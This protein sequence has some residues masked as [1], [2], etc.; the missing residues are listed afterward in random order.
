M[1]GNA[2]HVCGTQR[3]QFNLFC[4]E[5]EGQL[6]MNILFPTTAPSPTEAEE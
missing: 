4:R 3:P 1:N 5:R 2:C 6:A